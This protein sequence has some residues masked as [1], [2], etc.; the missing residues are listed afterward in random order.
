MQSITNDPVLKL[1]D[2]IRYMN[3]TMSLDDCRCIHISIDE[4]LKN[5]GQLARNLLVY[6]YIEQILWEESKRIA[7]IATISAYNTTV[8]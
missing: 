2:K 7:R 3:Q 1:I 4:Q 6:C 5:F 8:A